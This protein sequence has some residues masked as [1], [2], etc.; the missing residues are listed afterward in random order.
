MRVDMSLILLFAMVSGVATSNAAPTASGLPCSD[1][2]SACAAHGQGDCFADGRNEF[3]VPQNKTQKQCK[4]LFEKTTGGVS[5]AKV[6]QP[7]TDN[8]GRPCAEFLPNKFIDPQRCG[9]GM[10]GAGLP[11]TDIDACQCNGYTGA[12]GRQFSFCDAPFDEPDA[13]P[14]CFELPA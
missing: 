6:F 7:T 3:L 5:C 12:S 2:A 1:Q 8:P 9:P 13:A 4:T 10:Y 11:S 14:R